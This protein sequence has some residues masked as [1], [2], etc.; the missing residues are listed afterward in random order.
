MT[1]DIAAG[2]AGRGSGRVRVLAAVIAAQSERPWFGELALWESKPRAA[3]A[4]CYDPV[5]AA[6]APAA[7]RTGLAAAPRLPPRS[8]TLAPTSLSV[9]RS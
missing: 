2:R 1:R 3:T 6:R 4:T 7:P 5:K 9:A 8:S